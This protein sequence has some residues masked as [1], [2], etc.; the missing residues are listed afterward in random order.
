MAERE[1]TGTQGLDRGIDIL[2]SLVR[3]GA[4][5]VRLIDLQRELGLTRPTAHRLLL[6]LI[7]NRF[8]EQDPRT[9]RYCVAR[10]LLTI[11]WSML[12]WEADL[13]SLSDGDVAGLANDV[14]D[15]AHLVAR[16]GFETVCLHRYVGSY[17]IKVMTVDVG[18]RRP[19]GIGA[20][21][22]ALLAALPDVEVQDTLRVIE[23][24]LESYSPITIDKISEQVAACR[25]KGYATSGGYLGQR[26]VGLAVPIL[27]SSGVPIAALSVAAVADR[28]PPE[29]IPTV[30]GLIKKRRD[31]ISA[32]MQRT[33]FTIETDPRAASQNNTNERLENV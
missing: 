31:S 20:S 25:E 23:P 28:I 14:G 12:A 13:R 22:I 11:G 7:R 15:S 16:S 8:V 9:R 2:R 21:G 5:G 17:P 4:P 27:T 33:G 18:D 1:P 32:L 24:R 29:R 10:E 30:V 26:L 3:A 6:S 19:L